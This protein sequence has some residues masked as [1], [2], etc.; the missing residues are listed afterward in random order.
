MSRART[1]KLTIVMAIAAM[2]AM[3]FTS[4]TPPSP[5]AA[6]NCLGKAGV[7]EIDAAGADTGR[8][9]TAPVTTDAGAE[10][11]RDFGWHLLTDCEVTFSTTQMDLATLDV[12]GV[13]TGYCGASSAPG[14]APDAE[15]ADSNE[16]TLTAK[17]GSWSITLTNITW[18]SAGSVLVV[19][20][21]HDAGGQGV[22]S[23]EV[24]ASGGADCTSTQGSRGFDVNIV[25]ETL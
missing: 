5:E 15:D 18:E 11:E 4:S 8:G 24:Q 19:S 2:F 13:A 23:A 1:F 21:D 12:S 10:A 17:D 14:E 9:I 6:A 25:A 16:G 7:W 20:F 22:G 3:A